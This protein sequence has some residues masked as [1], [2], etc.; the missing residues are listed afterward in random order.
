M[1][2]NY[3][4]WSELGKCCMKLVLRV[5]SNDGVFSYHSGSSLSLWCLY[6]TRKFLSA[7]VLVDMPASKLFRIFFNDD[8]NLYEEMQIQIMFRTRTEIGKVFFRS[9]AFLSK[10]GQYFDIS[11]RECINFVREK[12]LF[13]WT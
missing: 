9:S 2:Q 10:D 6:N 5:I 1:K 7:R 12:C 8:T 4:P 3:S 13:V 11:L